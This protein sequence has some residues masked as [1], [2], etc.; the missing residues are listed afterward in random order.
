MIDVFSKN[1][2][3]RFV[4]CRPIAH[5]SD[6]EARQYA[7][8]VESLR[9]CLQHDLSTLL[10]LSEYTHRVAVGLTAGA[11]EWIPSFC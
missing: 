6:D 9:V 5:A 3:Q 8:I 4:S 10:R 1:R 2:W 7:V 11:V